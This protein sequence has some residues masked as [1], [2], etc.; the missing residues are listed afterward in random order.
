ME[1]KLREKLKGGK[2]ENV[3]PTNSKRMSAIRG[4]G[5]RTTELRLKMALIRRSLKGWTTH[6]R[7]IVGNPDFFFHDFRIAIFVDGCFWHGCPKCGHIPNVN[8][9]FWAEKI[10]RNQE[11][12]REKTHQLEASGIHVLRFWEHELEGDL[13]ACVDVIRD[14]L[15]KH[16]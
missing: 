5:N 6:P 4:R 2:F 11:R 7:G 16:T 12:D 14:T 3:S 15:R 9:P 1:R 13:Q 10:K 8:R